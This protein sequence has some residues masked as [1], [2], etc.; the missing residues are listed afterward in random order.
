MVRGTGFREARMYELMGRAHAALLAGARAGDGRVRRPDPAARG[1]ARRR[2]RG[3]GRS[4]TTRRSPQ[5]DH[6]QAQG[7][8]QQASPRPTYGRAGVGGREGRP[9]PA[10]GRPAGGVAGMC[11]HR[12]DS[13]RTPPRRRGGGPGR[14]PDWRRGRA[15]SAPVR[16]RRAA[17]PA[18]RRVRLRGRWADGAARAARAAAARGLRVLRGLGARALRPA[19]ARARSRRSRSRSPRS[20]WRGGSS[21]SWWPATAPRRPRCRRCATG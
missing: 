1:D 19:S 10:T 18:R 8:D 14:V 17:P 11:P 13:C 16:A 4:S 6:R 15:V 3:G 5:D 21:C 20:C 12:T 2:G 7:D 9:R